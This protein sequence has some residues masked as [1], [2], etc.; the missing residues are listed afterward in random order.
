MQKETDGL[1]DY[2]ANK[3]AI[4]SWHTPAVCKEASDE[5]IDKKVHLRNLEDAAKLQKSKVTMLMKG[6]Q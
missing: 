3:E 5:L 2:I 1:P 6:I 4:K